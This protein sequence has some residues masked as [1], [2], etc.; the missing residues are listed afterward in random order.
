MIIVDVDEG[1]MKAHDWTQ[2]TLCQEYQCRHPHE[3]T[4]NLE[5]WACDESFN[6]N[7]R[8]EWEELGHELQ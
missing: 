2:K 8:C 7:W 6:G 1:L 5:I 4:L 3:W